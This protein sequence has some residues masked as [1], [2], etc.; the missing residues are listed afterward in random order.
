[1]NQNLYIVKA[2]GGN[3][4]IIEV[5][6]NPLTRSSYEQHGRRLM[7]IGASYGVEQSGSLVIP[8]N[9]ALAHFE[10]SGGEFCGNAARSAALILFRLGYGTFLQFTMSGIK[11]PVLA[12]VKENDGVSIVSCT[13]SD[14]PLQLNIGEDGEKIVDL[15][16]IVHIILFKPFPDEYEQIHKHLRDRFY[17]NERDAV[18]VLWVEKIQEEGKIQIEPVVWVRSIETFFHETSCGSGS[19]ATAIAVG[20]SEVEVVQPTGESIFVKVD[21]QTVTLISTMEVTQNVPSYS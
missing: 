2:A 20:V 5:I 17:L 4:T 16:G 1:M 11:N 19:I 6:E 10:M 18:G 7:G 3:P 8:K 12:E 13:F 21:H 9:G 15:G 14:L